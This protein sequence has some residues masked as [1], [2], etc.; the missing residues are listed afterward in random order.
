MG[1]INSSL[2][3]RSTNS[4][5]VLPASRNMHVY[6]QKLVT[7]VAVALHAVGSRAA[8]RQ[9]SFKLH[10]ASNSPDGFEREVYLINGQQPG[11]LID[12]DEGDDLDIFVQNDLDVETTIHWHGLLQ[13]GTPDM[14]GV[15]GVT[16]VSFCAP[17]HGEKCT[18]SAD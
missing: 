4:Y 2:L 13:R 10:S 11:P 7:C 6:P 1:K 9:F 18:F 17:L 3:F 12:V 15:P 5:V 8:L 14:D 16:Q